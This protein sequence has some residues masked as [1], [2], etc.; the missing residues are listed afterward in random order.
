MNKETQGRTDLYIDRW[1]QSKPRDK[2][3]LATKV[4]GYSERSTFLRDNAKVVRVD[5]ANI[6][7]ELLFMER[8]VDSHCPGMVVRMAER[9][10][11]HQ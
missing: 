8:S 2:I 3:I 1:M 5:A 4:A 7:V 6:K 10:L 11:C 9:A